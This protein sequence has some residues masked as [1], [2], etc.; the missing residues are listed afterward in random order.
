MYKLT[1]R[2]GKPRA[3]QAKLGRCLL[4]NSG[5]SSLDIVEEASRPKG[6]SFAR[7]ELTTYVP[8]RSHAAALAGK[9]RRSRL[10]HCQVLL[11][12]LPAEN[13]QT[14]WK[15]Y[16][17]PFKITP[18]IW[19]VPSWKK[20]TPPAKDKALR[21]DTTF[22]FGTGL[23]ATTQMMARL[24]A[25]RKGHFCSLI[26]V[27]TGSGILAI[28]A[29]LY[30]AQKIW[31]IDNDPQAVETAAKNLK[32]NRCRIDYLATAD[33][34]RMGAK[35]R[36][37]FVAANLITDD[38]IRFREQLL[39]LVKPGG[40]LAISGIF[41]DNVARLKKE[42]RSPRLRCCASLKKKKWH[43]FLFTVQ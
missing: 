22:A 41:K 27:G 2:F 23:H 26:D 42:F 25:S 17:K 33:I 35:Q 12:R 29:H 14:R 19:V 31:A 24:I 9:L 8:G 13:W 34:A 32:R 7:T 10:K 11:S 39:A 16:L 37:D 38:L 20:F 21:I 30:G 1:L 5:I 40:C 15:K 4:E 3:N 28:L 6:A 36:F 43:A 18:R